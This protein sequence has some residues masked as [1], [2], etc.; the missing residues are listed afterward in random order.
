LLPAH[1]LDGLADFLESGLIYISPW[2]FGLAGPVNQ[3]RG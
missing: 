1:R 3:R 2:A